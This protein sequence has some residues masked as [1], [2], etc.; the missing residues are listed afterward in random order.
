MFKQGLP[1][2]LHHSAM[3]LAFNQHRVDDIAEIIDG[4]IAHNRHRAC[5]R[6]NLDLSNMAAIGIG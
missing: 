6:I 2:A 1:D 3:Q 5:V 4:C